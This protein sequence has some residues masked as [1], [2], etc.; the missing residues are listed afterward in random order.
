MAQA[1]E[2]A[3]RIRELAREKSETL[4]QRDAITQA[5]QARAS[6][7]VEQSRQEADS[8]RHDADQYVMD[9]LS[10][11]E[12]ALNR[13]LMVVRNGITHVQQEAATRKPS[14]SRNEPTHI[15]TPSTLDTSSEPLPIER[16]SSRRE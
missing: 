2:E 5:A 14:V 8:V 9:V 6:S 3:A 7:I 12:D 16:I 11:L 13:T 1:N 15:E 4:V 10:D